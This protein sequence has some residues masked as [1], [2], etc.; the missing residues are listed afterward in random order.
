MNKTQIKYKNT[1][2]HDKVESLLKEYPSEADRKDICIA[3]AFDY[4][5]KNLYV[6]LLNGR[7]LAVPFSFLRGENSEGFDG[8][9]ERD[10]N[11]PAP[12]LSRCDIVQD[13]FVLEL[14]DFSLEVAV[15][16][17]VFLKESA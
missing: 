9:V 8:I 7:E 16:S 6:K 3:T 1:L 14:G 13:G 2:T 15:L 11:M 10:E 17:H 4:W 12:D 5:T